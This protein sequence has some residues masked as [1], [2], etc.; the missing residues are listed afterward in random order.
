M[1]IKFYEWGREVIR[2]QVV[3]SCFNERRWFGFLDSPSFSLAVKPTTTT[4][5]KSFALPNIGLYFVLP[6]DLY[7]CK[8]DA[9]GWSG[10]HEQCIQPELGSPGV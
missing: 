6:S 9:L 7:A 1:D 2:G 5:I 4:Y 10:I 8:N 3:V